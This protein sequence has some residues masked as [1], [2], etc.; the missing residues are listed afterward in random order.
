MTKVDPESNEKYLFWSKFPC[1]WDILSSTF[2]KYSFPL[3]KSHFLKETVRH[4]EKP[5]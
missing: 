5:R 1:L 4:K 2:V 3:I